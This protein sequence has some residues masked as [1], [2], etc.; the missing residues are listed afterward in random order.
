MK[1]LAAAPVGRAPLSGPSCRFGLSG[2][3]RHA[4]DI[5]KAGRTRDSAIGLRRSGHFGHDRRQM[6]RL[7]RTFDLGPAGLGQGTGYVRARGS[8]TNHRGPTRISDAAGTN[9]ADHRGLALS[10]STGRD[11]APRSSTLHRALC[12]SSVGRGGLKSLA[13]QADG[14]ISRRL[15]KVAVSAGRHQQG[16][17]LHKAG[18]K[19]RSFVR[20]EGRRH[21]GP[22]RWRP[23]RS[24]SWRR[25][26]AAAAIRQEEP[27]AQVE[28]NATYHPMPND[29]TLSGAIRHAQGWAKLAGPL[30][31]T[32]W[33]STNL[34]DGQRCAA[35]YKQYHRRR[36]SR[37]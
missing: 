27:G 6:Q 25:R 32:D 30:G 4:R 15:K 29:P 16:R 36:Q 13:I 12:D 7:V 17:D 37:R 22:G 9:K 28:L 18:P 33:S 35:I 19:A 1:S 20:Y 5:K 10:I 23:D 14:P 21:H 31:G 34:K 2:A 24:T 8:S 11:F 3:C 26:V